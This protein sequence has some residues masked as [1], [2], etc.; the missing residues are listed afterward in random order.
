MKLPV[1]MLVFRPYSNGSS[2]SDS[3]GSESLARVSGFT[4]VGQQQSPN[5]RG[6]AVEGHH[7]ADPLC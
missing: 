7:M 2:R 1:T 6:Q 4:G 5:S 3:T